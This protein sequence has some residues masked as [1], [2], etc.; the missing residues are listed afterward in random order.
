MPKKSDKLRIISAKDLGRLNLAEFCP[1]CF[2]L[3]RHVD[4]PPAVFPGI[5]SVIDS[6]TKKG[7]ARAFLENGKPP[8][9]LPLKNLSEV[10]RDNTYF[11]LPIPESGWILTGYPDD[12]FV[13]EDGS[14]Q[15]ADYKTAKFTGRQDA[16]LPIY[17]VQLNCYAFLAEAYG[18]KPVSK[19][20][21]VY[22]E[23]NQELNRSDDF[24]LGFAPR[25]LDLQLRPEVVPRL[26]LEARKILDMPKPPPA[27]SACKGICRWAN[28]LRVKCAGEKG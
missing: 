17:E 9:W 7:V 26:L 23:P 6:V 8:P 15:I 14:Y 1:R 3:E 27:H 22:Y 2:W 5:F 21:L 16:L 12:V 13:L 24:L 19:I 25:V 20:S 18:L 28:A 4:K 11:K 10:E